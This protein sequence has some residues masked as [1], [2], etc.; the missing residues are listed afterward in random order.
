MCS[1]DDFSWCNQQTAYAIMHVWDES[2]VGKLG[3]KQLQANSTLL[4]NKALFVLVL[5]PQAEVII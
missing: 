2:H 4:G 3:A 1:A 5:Y